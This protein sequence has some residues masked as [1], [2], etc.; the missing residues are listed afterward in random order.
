MS[1]ASSLS[2]KQ[3]HASLVRAVADVERAEKNLVLWFGEML[4]REL[5]RDLGFSSIYQYAAVKLSFSRSK[6][7]QLVQ[8]C[9]SLRKLPRLREAVGSGEVPWTKARTLV[10]VATPRTETRWV[11]E[12]KR[13]GRQALQQ[14]VTATR[15]AARKTGT[16]DTEIPFDEPIEETA[17]REAPV[18]VT[19]RFSPTEYARYEA[20]IA[21]LGPDPTP[22]KI[23]EALSVLAEHRASDRGGKRA[24]EPAYQVVV[25]RCPDCGSGSI[26]TT[27]GDLPVDPATLRQVAC[28]SRQETNGRNTAVIPPSIRRNVL[29]RDGHRCRSAG[30]GRTR[31]LE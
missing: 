28:D 24:G 25:R 13:N 6:T 9:R 16:A 3:V 4:E 21:A 1:T 20:L 17:P 30:C 23:L 12:A 15:K 7:A 26:P 8:V 22:A 5:F 10:P 18:D 19:L 29:E 11:E 14:K 2:A 27:R 31:H